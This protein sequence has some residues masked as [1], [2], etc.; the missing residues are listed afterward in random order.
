MKKKSALPVT[1][2]VHRNTVENRAKRERAV[3]AQKRVETIM[4]ENDVRA[5]AFVAIGANG[6]MYSTWDTGAILPQWAFPATVAYALQRDLEDHG[7][8]EDWKPTL[9][10]RGSE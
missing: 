7:V 6:K 2:S 9:P 4:R 10:I 3:Y 5:Y 8:E 1:L